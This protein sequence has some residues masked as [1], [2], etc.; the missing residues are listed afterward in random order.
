[1]IKK[2]FLG[3]IFF[4]LS[5][6]SFWPDSKIP[7][8][9]FSNIDYVGDGIRGHRLDIYYPKEIG[10]KLR[11]IHLMG[12]NKQYDKIDQ[13]VSKF[14]NDNDQYPCLITIPGSGWRS[15]SGKNGALNHIKNALNKL[16]EKGFVLVTVN[17]R[18]SSSA[19]FPAQIH[20][21][22]AAVRFLKGNAKNLRIDPN[23]IGIQGFSSG[24][25]LAALMGT[26]SNQNEFSYDGTKMDLNGSLGEHLDQSS[27]VHAVIDWFG[28]SNFLVMDDCAG[29][30]S[31]IK[32]NGESSP[33]SRFVGGPI[34]NHK[35]VSQ[36]ANPITH[37]SSKTPPFLI[38]HGEK[39]TSV[40][41]CQSKI[42]HDA[43][44]KK[45]VSSELIIEKEGMHS[46]VNKKIFTQKNLNRMV[47][48]LITEYQN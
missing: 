14:Q 6:F 18:G 8:P 24:G 10:L 29:K 38:V 20:D 41:S 34:Q 15:N 9:T 22:K 43:L 2:V 45:G 39:D 3:I 4:C 12:M 19:I 21:I 46:G 16:F 48:F 13:I 17:H 27:D 44:I 31:I 5:S 26:T 25:H 36:L 23:F 1:M 28:P 30:E 37:I 11:N 33:E 42:L 40:P 47:N 7:N 35:I 32:H